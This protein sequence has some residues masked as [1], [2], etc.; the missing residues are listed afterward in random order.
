MLGEGAQVVGLDLSPAMIEEARA[1]CGERGRF[2]VADLAEPIPLDPKSVDG[3]TCSLALHYLEDWFVPLKSFA[4]LLRPGGWVVLSLDHPFSPPLPSQRRGYFDTE[5]V[6]DIWEKG[7]VE[8]TQHFWHRP[9]GAVIGA[10][11]DAGFVVDRIREAQP[12]RETVRRFPEELAQAETTPSF[13]V[14][15]LLLRDAGAPGLS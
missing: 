1:R 13:I 8:V 6:T 5:L 4:T 7:D 11:A 10:F 15:R 3:I 9:L 14:F 2:L 12:D